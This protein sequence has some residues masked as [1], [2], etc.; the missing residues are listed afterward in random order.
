MSGY[1]GGIFEEKSTGR[2]VYFE[3]GTGRLVWS[4]DATS[5]TSWHEVQLDGTPILKAIYTAM[6]DAHGVGAGVSLGDTSAF[7]GHVVIAT[8]D[9]S[10]PGAYMMTEEEGNLPPLWD[11][12]TDGHRWL[13]STINNAAPVLYRLFIGSIPAHRQIV[14]EKGAAIYGATELVDLPNAEVLGTDEN[15]VV[16]KRTLS[17]LGLLQ[18]VLVTKGGSAV[19]GGKTLNFIQGANVTL[20]IED[21]GDVVDITVA[22]SGGGGG[23]PQSAGNGGNGGPGYVQ[24]R[25]HY[26]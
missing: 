4:A 18:E 19:G 10:N 26:V 17:S 6:D 13:G 22:S 24:V 2:I 3:R 20:T 5:A 8:T 23:G 16:E 11:I 12:F 15:G 25:W 21:Q 9:V 1:T 7:A 14:A